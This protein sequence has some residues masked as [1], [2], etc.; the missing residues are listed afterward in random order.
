MASFAN[1]AALQIY[2][3]HPQ[4][5]ALGAQLVNMCV[6]GHHGIMVFDLSV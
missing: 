1:Q 6:N 2:A 5:I 4:H 3:N